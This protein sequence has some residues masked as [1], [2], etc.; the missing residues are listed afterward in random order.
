ME[1]SKDRCTSYALRERNIFVYRYQLDYQ[2]III[3]LYAAA[4]KTLS[5]KNIIYILCSKCAVFGKTNTTY[6]KWSPINRWDTTE[7][8]SNTRWSTYQLDSTIGSLWESDNGGPM[9]AG[10]FYIEKESWKTCS[11][12]YKLKW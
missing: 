8:H 10:S 1:I 2:S 6:E 7:H 11:L 4:Y 3:S 9:A 5:M 12:R